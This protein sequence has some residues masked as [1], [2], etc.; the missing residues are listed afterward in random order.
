MHFLSATARLPVPTLMLVI[1]FVLRDV[2]ALGHEFQPLLKRQSCSSAEIRSQC[3]TVGSDPSEC[4][5]FIC[6]S[7]TEL[8]PAIASCCQRSGDLNK[9]QCI[10]DNLDTD[11]SS[12]PTTDSSDTSI[13]TRPTSSFQTTTAPADANAGCS[14]LLDKQSSCKAATPG[15]EY[16]IAWSSQASCFCYS[17]S[18]YVPRSF[19]NYYSSCLSY[20]ETAD[21]ELYSSL[22]IGN[23]VAISTPCASIGD[24]EEA[25]TRREN[26]VSRTPSPGTTPTGAGDS[27]PT[28]VQLTGGVSSRVGVCVSQLL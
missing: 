10:S 6:D 26:I 7:C 2:A 23:T 27:Q 5:D 22:T 20:L 24:L 3:L 8:D 17:S 25:T 19:D 12:S 16:I 1:C 28:S 21:T 11:S 15:F 18:S 4:I 14:S 9:A 13:R